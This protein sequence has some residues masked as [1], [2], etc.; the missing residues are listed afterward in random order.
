MR[1][2][3]TFLTMLV[4]SIAYANAQVFR[5]MVIE[6][7][8]G[9]QVRVP[10]ARIQQVT[11]DSIIGLPANLYLVGGNGEWNSEKVQRFEHVEDSPIYYYEFEG[12]GGSYDIWF[13]FGD[14]AAL[15]SIANG[16][17]D[18]LYGTTGSN[19]DL[20]GAFNRRYTLGQDKSFCVDGKA[21]FYRFTVNM[22]DMTYEITSQASERFLYFIGATDGWATSEQRL[23]SPGFNGIYTGF[24]YIADPNGWGNEFK[25]QRE[26]GNWDTQLNT[27]TFGGNISGD[28]MGGGDTESNLKAVAGE[29][30]YYVTVDLNKPALNAVKVNNMNLV[31]EYNGWNVADDSQQ[32]TW[33]AEN[34]C[35][36]KTDAVLTQSEWKFAAN[37]SWDI[38]LGSDYN[39][40]SKLVL[41]GSNLHVSGS[42]VKLYPTRRTSDNI[43][44]TVENATR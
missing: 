18:Y 11:F 9:S 40:E 32:M 44:F 36:V 14:D 16:N 30:V 38:N 8:D 5:Y 13:A 25:F 22:A 33:D 20:Q 3:L 15:D 4:L 24:L 28:V 1:R 42:I 39:D 6:K 34:Y 10:V 29:G 31:G 37:N 2:Y 17:W 19:T 26:P 41:E 7:D 21:P 27:G 43:Y 35:F 23:E 12:N